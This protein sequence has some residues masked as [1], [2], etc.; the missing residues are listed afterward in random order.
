MA[1]RD[2]PEQIR[3]LDELRRHSTTDPFVSFDIVTSSGDKYEVRERLQIAFGV[4]AC[5][6]VLPRTGIRVIRSN[7]ISAI[8]V[9]EPAV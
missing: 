7:Q 3:F 6:V 1:E 5:V 4:D 9:H 2:Q 8:H